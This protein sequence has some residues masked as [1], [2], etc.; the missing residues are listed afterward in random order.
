MRAVKVP[1]ISNISLPDT[2]GQR[3]WADTLCG[4]AE[5]MC[6][7]NACETGRTQACKSDHGLD[8]SAQPR[9]T[10]VS[11]SP[12]SSRFVLQKLPEKLSE[13]IKAALFPLFSRRGTPLALISRGKLAARELIDEHE[14]EDHI[15]SWNHS[16]SDRFLSEF[17][18]RFPG[19][20][21]AGPRL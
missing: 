18:V 19:G 1:I 6:E 15:T 3:A 21:G 17:G 2:S 9:L 12:V 14:G 5:T 16:A 4:N 8:R 7:K 11:S 10:P 20:V 13:S